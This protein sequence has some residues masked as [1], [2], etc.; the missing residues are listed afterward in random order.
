MTAELQSASGFLRISS[1]LSKR[2]TIDP[3]NSRSLGLYLREVA[4][5][6]PLPSDRRHQEPVQ[7]PVKYAYSYADP[8]PAGK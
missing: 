7:Y 4:R 3:K 2:L 1:Q 8:I 5:A 6:S